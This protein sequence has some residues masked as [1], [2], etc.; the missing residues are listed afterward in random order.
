MTIETAELKATP[1]R[2]RRL[3]QLGY[4]D[5][6]ALENGLRLTGAIPDR[7]G[8]ARFIDYLLLALGALFFVAGLFFFVAY[9]WE[10]LPRFARFGILEGAIVVIAAMAQWSGLRRLG[11]KIALT[12]A[13]LLVG[14]LLA[15]FGQEYQSGADSYTLFGNWAL[16]ITGWVLIG[17]FDVLW[18][19][20]LGLL[21]LTLVLFWIQLYPGD[22]YPQL[23]TLFL[24][25]AVALLVWELIARRARWWQQRWLQRITAIVA[26]GWILWPTLETIFALFDDYDQLPSIHQYGPLIYGLFLLLVLFV[27]IR[28]QPDLFMVTVAFFSLIVVL[29]TLLSASLADYDE[30]LAYFITGFAVILQAGV[31][32]T[33]LRR[34]AHG[35]EEQE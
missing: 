29:T 35:W 5:R 12:V 7:S 26:F 25:N 13:A 32:V 4:L 2:V 11:G 1:A 28:L 16:L 24:L 31:A 21:N 8:W 6:A 9:N 27:Y 23:E 15:V 10:E 20:W 18:G 33:S 19:V 14:A 17:C 34:I 22:Q 30:V 3:A